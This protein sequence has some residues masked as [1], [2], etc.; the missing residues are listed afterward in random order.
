LKSKTAENPIRLRL[1]FA[2]RLALGLLLVYSGLIHIVQPY[3]FIHSIAAYQVLPRDMVGIVGTLLPSVQIVLGISILFFDTRKMS[4]LLAT[5]L[6]AT[7]AWFQ[8]NALW[9][10]TNIDCGCFGF[11]SKHV[12]FFTLLIPISCTLVSFILFFG[13]W[14]S[15]R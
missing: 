11:D 6:F 15:E 1:D 2:L 3:Y 14:K 12:S 8:G 9:R 4:L 7:F 13:I 10:G 5:I